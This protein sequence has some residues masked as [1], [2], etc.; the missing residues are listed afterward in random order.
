MQAYFDMVNAAGRHLRPQARRSCKRPR[1][2]DRPAEPCSR[3]SRASPTTTRS[4]RSSP[5]C[6]SPAPTC[7]PRPSSRPS[8]G[9]S[10]P[11]WRRPSGPSHDNIFGSL[12][13]LCFSC[14][15]HVPAVARQQERLHQGRRARVRQGHVGVVGP[16]A[17]G[18]TQQLQQVPAQRE[19]RVLRRLARLRGRHH[20]RRHPDEGSGVQFVITCMD[21]N[22]VTKLAKEM[23]KQGLNAVQQLPERLR[24]RL[25]RRRA[26]AS[27]TAASSSRSSC[28]GK[29]RRSPRDAAVPRRTRRRTNVTTVRAHRGR[30]DHGGR[31][32]RRAQARRARSSRKQ[33]VIDALNT[34]TD[35]IAGRSHRPDRLDQAAQR[36][37][38]QPWPVRSQYECSDVPED[39]RT[40][41][42]CRSSPSRAS[43][44][45]ASTRTRHAPLPNEPT[46]MSFAPGGVG[47]TR[48]RADRAE[49]G[50]L[51]DGQADRR[52]HRRR[53]VRQRLRAARGRADAD[54]Q[55]VGRLQPRVR[56]AGVRRPARSTTNCTS[57]NTGR[58][59]LAFVIAV[60]IVAPLIGVI[61]DRVAVP[62]SS[63]ARHRWRGSIT[64]LG[65]LVAIPADRDALVRRDRT[66]ST[67]PGSC[68]NGRSST[69]RSA[70]CSYRDDLATIVIRGGRRRS[71]HA[72]V[73]LHRARLR[74]R[75]VVESPRM[76]ELAGID[77]DRDQHERR[78][79][80]RASSPGSRA[81]C[82]PPLIGQV[83]DIYYTT[84]VV[85]AIAAAVLGVAH[86][87]PA[88]VRG[89]LGL[90]VRAGDPVDRTCRRTACSRATC[91]RRC[92]SSC[93]FLVLIFSPRLRNRK[94]LT[95]PLA[96]VD[97]PPPAAGRRR[98]AAGSSP[99]GTRGLGVSFVPR[100]VG[101]YVFFH[102]N[103]ERRGSGDPESAIF[104]IIFCSIIV[105][106]GI[107]GEISLCAGDVRRH[108][109]VRVRRSSSRRA[110]MSVLVAIIVGAVVAAAVGALLA[111]P[112][113]RL[114]G[115]FLS[116]ATLR[117]RVVLRQRDG[118]VR[119]G[120]AAGVP[121]RRR[122][123]RSSGRI[124]FAQRQVASSCSASRDPGDRR[125]RRRSRCGTA[126][127]GGT[128]RRSRGSEAAAASIGINPTRPASS[129]S[130]CRPAIA[131]RRRCACSRATK[132]T[133]TRP[134]S[135][136]R[137]GLFWVV[138][139][140]TPR[141]RAP[142][143][144]RSRPR[145]ASSSSRS[146]VLTDWLPWLVNH[147]QPFV[148][149]AVRC[150][151]GSRAI[152]FGL[153]AVTYAKHPEG[154]LECEQ[155]ASRSPEAQRAD[156]PV[157]RHRS[158]APIRRPR[159]CP[160]PRRR[161]SAS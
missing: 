142:S 14:A 42:S 110:G 75:A 20:R 147:I 111:V 106:T 43:R 72:A 128:S 11:R 158:A 80:C 149:S 50:L 119:A 87:H 103:V 8:S 63:A 79:S 96:G 76:T 153:G 18:I 135:T 85:A 88:R 86:E 54:V 161:A 160:C 29:R 121:R 57:H 69:T 141:V 131:G 31:V 32:R 45:S 26:A 64:A 95:D 104:A 21:T 23:K 82:S 68:P 152:F 124:D 16:C 37:D 48:I 33:K 136:R 109:R 15:G 116:L 130:R 118:E 62:L 107:A 99:I 126:R 67:R 90:G 94:E 112:A 55:D 148:P 78:G 9:T 93:L 58:S 101:Y 74:M 44:G 138:L 51:T 125:R 145:S 1:R 102:G 6:S 156:R 108:R 46:H 60:F 27:S 3:C 157:Q 127:R 151:P 39:R 71:A 56:R 122:R 89:R 41:S 132:V 34:Q 17:D 137:S 52:A 133:R 73:P 100:A 140:V 24:P 155:A 12:G 13:A 77:S 25:R 61:L 117:L 84:L 30:L 120:W 123:A 92:R 10:T 129:R 47:L 65:L 19:G 5:R 97:P 150:R 146:L 2:P 59:S 98:S 4:R 91:A 7:W 134:T 35:G 114:G 143:K 49:S 66:R 70:P 22:E 36:S 53:R 113:L 105:I 38:E 159:K 139:V 83:G 154:M 28:R 115:I 40:A 81:C 144:A